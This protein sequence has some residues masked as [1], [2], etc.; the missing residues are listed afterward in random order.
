VAIQKQKKPGGRQATGR[1]S[2]SQK[3]FRFSPILGEDTAQH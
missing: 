3:F 1:M 2:Q